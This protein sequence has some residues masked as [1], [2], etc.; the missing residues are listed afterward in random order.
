LPLQALAS[1]LQVGLLGLE[2]GRVV[3]FRLGPSLV[4]LWQGGW[5]LK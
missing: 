2:S 3:L 5:F 4:E 1:L